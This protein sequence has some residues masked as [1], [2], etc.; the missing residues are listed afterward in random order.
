MKA[1]QLVAPQTFEIKE[2]PIPAPKEGEVLVRLQRVSVCGSDMRSYQSVVEEDYPF[3]PGR[4]C[5][6]CAG[7]IEDSRADGFIEG[8]RVIVL[9]TGPGGLSEYVVAPTN[10]LILLPEDKDMTTLIMCQP[11][12]TVLYACRQAGSVLGDTVVIQGQGA[13]GLSFTSLMARQGAAQVIGVDP[14]DYR[15]EKARQVG[16][17][18]TFN[19]LKEDVVQAVADLAG[20]LMADVVVQAS[21]DSEALNQ[22]FDLVRRFGRVVSFGL[23]HDNVIPLDFFKMHRK[24]AVVIST[25]SASSDDPTWGIKQVV[26]LVE[27]G[28]MDLSWM[29]THRMPFQDVQKAYDMYEGRTDNIIKVV[30]EV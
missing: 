23:P 26:N 25:S 5:H 29:I 11:V 16:A 6:E 12:G 7:V 20:G 27:Q 21:G 19:P 13:I 3:S 2:F 10:R 15:L 1:A 28:R 9:P 8:Q 4:P 18:H 17:T 22:S 24:Q 30:L 14:L